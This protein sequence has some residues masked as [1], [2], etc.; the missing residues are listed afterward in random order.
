MLIAY[1]ISSVTASMVP[2]CELLAFHPYDFY[3]GNVK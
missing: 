2:T 3:D 1:P